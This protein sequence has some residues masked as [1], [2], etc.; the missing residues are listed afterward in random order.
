MGLAPPLWAGRD[1]PPSPAAVPAPAATERRAGT[2]PPADMRG[3]RV[4]MRGPR[5]EMREPRAE[6]RKLAAAGLRPRGDVHYY[7]PFRRRA[8]P[9]IAWLVGALAFLAAP[10]LLALAVLT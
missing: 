2:E 9:S 10:A 3:P 5:I 4:E 1:A 8:R 7:G 6:V